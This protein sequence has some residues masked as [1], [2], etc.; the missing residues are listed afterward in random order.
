MK[1]LERAFESALW[2][3]RFVMLG[4]VTFS[5]LMALGA[6]YMAT[7]DALLLPELMWAYSD[8][9]L[10]AEQRSEVRAKA[11]TLIVKS[12]D[13]YVITAILIIFSLGLYEFFISKL[14]VARESP[15]APRLLHI[16]GLEDL[17]E[18]IAKLLVLVLVIEFFQRA[19]LLRID[20]ALD[21]LYLALGIV[22]IGLTLYLGKLKPRGG[23][24]MH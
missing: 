11:L 9:A 23:S 18:R 22:L 13:G 5:T 4:G 10:T 8:A 1:K 15:L 20:R 14:D 19:L 3:S 2:A 16:G 21:L 7:V 12:V 17:K 6:F 24:E